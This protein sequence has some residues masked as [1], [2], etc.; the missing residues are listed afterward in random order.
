MKQLILCLSLLH[1]IITI[2]G[3]SSD[4]KVSLQILKHL[5]PKYTIS[6][7]EG[8]KL[9]VTE[10]WENHAT[11]PLKECMTVELDNQVHALAFEIYM[12]DVPEDYLNMRKGKIVKESMINEASTY[13]GTGERLIQVAFYDLKKNSFIGKPEGFPLAE[14]LW[15]DQDFTDPPR[16]D[17]I[18]TFKKIENCTNT[19]ILSIEEYENAKPQMHYFFKY[20]DDQILSKSLKTC[21]E[22]FQEK[23]NRLWVHHIENCEEVENEGAVPENVF[24]VIFKW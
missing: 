13:K 2:S 3:Q 18:L 14:M 16:T 15:I 8:D 20:H 19:I 1:I 11:I 6:Q 4:Q 17:K 23:N 21:I 22:S 12:S 24:R 9:F 7:F 10:V 5:F